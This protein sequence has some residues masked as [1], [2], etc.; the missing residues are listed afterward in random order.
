MARAWAL[1]EQLRAI[2]R[3]SDA[4]DA[5]AALVQWFAAS[6]A[7]GIAQFA[8]L[9][10]KVERNAPHILNTIRLGVSNAR[11]EALNNKIKLLIRIAYGFRTIDTLISLIMLFCSS[12]KIPWMRKIASTP[13]K[14]RVA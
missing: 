3:M 2:L 1:K 6:R 13:Q 4:D 7:S 14:Q 8:E 10:D 9:A 11:V 12:I 5:G